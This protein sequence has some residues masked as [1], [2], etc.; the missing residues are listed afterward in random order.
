MILNWRAILLGLEQ[1]K[2]GFQSLFI[3]DPILKQTKTKRNVSPMKGWSLDY[4]S[5]NFIPTNIFSNA[6]KKRLTIC[7]TQISLSEE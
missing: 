3:K 2:Y 4:E 7:D 5:N 1:L 6:A